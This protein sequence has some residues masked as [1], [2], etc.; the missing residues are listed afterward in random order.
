MPNPL[1]DRIDVA[2]QRGAELHQRLERSGVEDPAGRRT[3]RYLSGASHT[4]AMDHSVRI[5]FGKVVDGI[6]HCQWYKVYTDGAKAP[7]PC[8]ALSGSAMLPFGVRDHNPISPGACVLVALRPQIEFGVIVGVVPPDA[9]DALL[10]DFVTQTSAHGIKVDEASRFPFSLARSGSISDW[11]AGRP[12][13]GTLAGERGW[14]SDTG[15]GLF[16]DSAMAFLR[17]DD[18]CG[19]WAFYR[20]QLTRIQGHNLQ[21]YT[22][23][24]VHEALDDEGEATDYRGSTP[25][26]WE[27]LGF[28]A[29]E[30]VDTRR[31]GAEESQISTPH[32]SAREPLHDDQLGFHRRRE[33][34][35]YLGNVSKEIVNLP[36]VTPPGAERYSNQSIY[37]GVFETHTAPN[38]RHYVR[39]AKGLTLAKRHLIP[40]PKPML[41]PE[42]PNGDHQANYRAAGR[43]GQG[44]EHAVIEDMDA[45][46]LDPHRVR[47]AGS[48]DSQT[49]AMNWNSQVGVHYHALDYFAPNESDVARETGL[50]AQARNYFDQLRGNAKSLSA[51]DPVRLNVDHR[52]GGADYWSNYSYLD[53]LEDGGVELGDGFGSGIRCTG[54][55]IYID[56]PGDLYL[57]PGRRLVILAG[58]DVIVR[59]A[60][61]AELSTTSG[62]VRLSSGRHGYLAAEGGLVLESRSPSA[63]FS[64]LRDRIGS[65]CAPTGIVLRSPAA[66]VTVWSAS[67]YVSATEGINLDCSSGGAISTYS[68]SFVRYVEEAADHFGQF[69]V[70]TQNVAA[71]HRY[72]SDGVVF[73][74]GL[75]VAADLYCGGEAV[76]KRGAFSPDG[77][78]QTGSD[79]GMEERSRDSREALETATRDVQA[80]SRSAE[81]THQRE[82][83]DFLHGEDREGSSRTILEGAFSFRTSEQYGAEDFRLFEARWQQQARGWNI[84]LPVWRE[85]AVT[86]SGVKTMPYP[87]HSVATGSTSFATVDPTLFDFSSGHAKDRDETSYKGA[88][89]GV[90]KLQS[91]DGNYPIIG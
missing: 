64:T 59:A 5:V 88:R 55:D 20:D 37:P 25:F 10:S 48:V 91:L 14:F 69:S 68:A 30:D 23:A 34:G 85:R 74:G 7:I 29:L 22:G 26:P 49:A 11:S 35:G 12:H 15:G 16:V 6:A 80:A 3:D 17:A 33:Y 60:D 73:S 41:R 71:T 84:G 83:V 36:P 77:S 9:G 67:T 8:S 90:P 32:Y 45:G 21:V 51:P 79:E 44:P 75:T 18:N 52:S 47:A 87:G 86:K 4:L 24:S 82:Y 38:G 72:S 65:D 61:S 76:L 66:N 53:L 42:D 56:P 58:K 54:G 28:F 57:R 89:H 78:F 40:T 81:V 27:N 63:D 70:E 13:D 62:D 1:M 2:L 50:T 31:L 43:T 39:S 46:L 19:I